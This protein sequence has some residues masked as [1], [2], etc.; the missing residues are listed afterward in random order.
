MGCQRNWKRLEEVDNVILITN[1][2]VLP[3]ERT[4]ILNKAN[5]ELEK[6]NKKDV[7]FD[8]WDGAK[9]YNVSIQYPIIKLWLEEQFTTAQ[10]QLF[11]EESYRYL[12]HSFFVGRA[13]ITKQLFSFLESDNTLL[14]VTGPAG[15][16]KT[17]LC[18]EFFTTVNAQNDW[19]ILSVA[20]HTIDFD[21][22]NIALAGH[23]NYIVFIDDAH[24]YL[25]TAIADFYHLA[26]LFRSNKVKIVL[27]ARNHFH[28]RVLS[29]L[30]D[31]ERKTVIEIKLEKLSL[32]E[33]KEVF[34]RSLASFNLKNHLDD[35][36]LM[37]RGRPVL[38]VAIIKVVQNKLPLSSIKNDSFLNDYVTSVY[39]K[40]IQT[41]SD[42]TGIEKLK[43]QNL[44][45]SFCLIEP[46]IYS[47]IETIGMLSVNEDMPIEAV[48]GFFQKLLQFG[49]ASGN[50]EISIKPDYY[51]DVILKTMPLSWVQRRVSSYQ[52]YIAN[53]IRNLSAVEET[54]DEGKSDNSLLN[55]LLREYVLK[56]DSA[57]SIIDVNAILNTLE[58]VA[59]QKP[60]IA[61]SAIEKILLSP[62]RKIGH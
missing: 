57:H 14:T 47:N 55:S 17:R 46:I 41:I 24:E 8:L 11:N 43:Y 20:A 12:D 6:L 42:D 32:E 26:S 60:A 40:F 27:T 59:Y 13:E 45:A 56:I 28:S 25:P 2:A 37:S 5:E 52:H 21:K 10:L 50:Y 30:K 34:T 39:S 53:I 19:T 58:Q 54:L 48:E 29:L 51:S 3:Q 9:L 7:Y 18:T 36:I 62:S 16:G 31:Y 33:T 61:L 35:F 15:I 1:V 49:L 38:I 22:I 44:L 23:K 4:E